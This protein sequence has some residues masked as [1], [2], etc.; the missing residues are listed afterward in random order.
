MER[1]YSHRWTRVLRRDELS[2]FQNPVADLLA[3]LYSW[4]NEVCDANEKDL[5][6]L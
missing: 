5:A 3:C 4:A 2:S 1:S 6:R